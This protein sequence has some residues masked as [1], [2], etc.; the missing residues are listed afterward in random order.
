[1]LCDEEGIVDSMCTCTSGDRGV[2]CSHRATV[3]LVLYRVKN[4]I[5]A[6]DPSLS[7]TFYKNTICISGVSDSNENDSEYDGDGDTDMK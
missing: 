2:I 4:D 3:L 5:K 1:M 6:P 7:S